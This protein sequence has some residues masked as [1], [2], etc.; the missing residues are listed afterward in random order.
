MHFHNVEKAIRKRSLPLPFLSYM[1]VFR[2]SE[3]PPQKKKW[4][5]AIKWFGAILTNPELNFLPID[6][7]ALLKV[8]LASYGITP[9]KTQWRLCSSIQMHY[10]LWI[11]ITHSLNMRVPRWQTAGSCSNKFQLVYQQ[12][13]ERFVW[14]R[15]S[16]S[17]ILKR[18][19]NAT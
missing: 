3:P 15:N 6:R 7:S 5:I 2:I 13:F 11:F 18:P 17:L 4:K 9:E 14:A 10:E 12:L 8:G 1:K 19:K 16:I